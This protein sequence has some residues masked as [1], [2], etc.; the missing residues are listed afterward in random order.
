LEKTAG[1]LNLVEN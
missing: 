1:N